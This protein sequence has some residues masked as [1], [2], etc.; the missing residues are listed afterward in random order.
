MAIALTHND[1]TS[2]AS[3]TS[4]NRTF[5][6]VSSGAVLICAITQMSSGSRTYAVSDDVNGAWPAAI[7]SLI[8][9]GVTGPTGRHAEIFRFESSAAGDPVITVTV[10]GGAVPFQMAVWAITGANPTAED[11]GTDFN[12]SA[13][14]TMNAMATGFNVSAGAFVV[15]CIAPTASVTSSTLDADYTVAI[16]SPAVSPQGVIGYRLIGGSP[17]T[18]EQM[19][20]TVGTGRAYVGAAASFAEAVATGN[21]RRRTLLTAV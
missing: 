21:R 7:A 8:G 16:E 2:S 1:A 17:I 6:G 5:T 18:D 3:A 4:L 9:D 11:T 12:L 14:T 13:D 10:T 19:L 20:W 15:A